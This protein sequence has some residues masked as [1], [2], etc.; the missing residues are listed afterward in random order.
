LR[1]EDGVISISDD[2]T[3]RIW[4]KRDAGNYWPSV[5][6]IMPAP[7]TTMDF[8]HETKRLFVGMENG[9]ISE[10]QVAEDFNRMSHQ[11]NYLAHQGK[12]SQVVFSII[13]EWVLS[14][15]RDKYFN[16]HCSET[17]RRLGGFQCNTCCTA[18][19]FDMQSKHAFIGDQ[20]GQITMLKIE[21]SGFKPVTTLKGHS[22]A[23]RCLCWDA[24]K[25]MLYSGSID[26]V[27]ICWDI[28]GKKGT[29]YELQGHRN[30]VTSLCYAPTSKLL[31]SSGEDNMII[32]WKMSTKRHETPDWAESD[33]CQRCSRPFFWN[34]KA[35]VDQK[36]IGLRQHHCR[37]CG[38]AV[39]DACSGNK[40][41]IPIMGYEHSVR[42]CDECHSVITDADR[43]SLATFYDGKHSIMYLDLDEARCQLLTAGS[44][45]IIKLWDATN[46]LQGNLS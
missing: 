36:T 18:L 3:V 7:A 21:E 41:A 37:R 13:T 31:L 43:V 44:D 26:Q 35:M 29:A 25:Q 38:K 14:A 8:N 42:V 10:F 2:K 5:C 46:L 22:D 33:F 27:I 32:S 20:S 24:T 16:W 23:I 6:H 17:G 45:R 39:C 19:Q 12:V 30:K 28:G 4:L 15:G 1:G 11:R 34:F 9:S 40:S